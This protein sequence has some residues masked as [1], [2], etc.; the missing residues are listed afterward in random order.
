MLYNKIIYVIFAIFAIAAAVWYY[1]LCMRLMLHCYFV[2][3]DLKGKETFFTWRLNMYIYTVR[4][5]IWRLCRRFMHYK[6]ET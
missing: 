1:V 6:C 2:V 3:M 5:Y 4:I